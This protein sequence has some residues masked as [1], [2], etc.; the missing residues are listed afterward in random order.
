MEGLEAIIIPIQKYVVPLY[1]EVNPQVL[2]NLE[3][4]QIRFLWELDL[5]QRLEFNRFVIH[6]SELY[7]LLL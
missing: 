1:C 7:K 4:M 6:L 3:T 2:S 5:A